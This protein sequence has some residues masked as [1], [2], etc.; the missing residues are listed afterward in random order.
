M[1]I[2]DRFFA[3]LQPEPED[4]ESAPQPL[5]H[6]YSH[7]AIVVL[8]DPGSGKSASFEQGAA[9][10][11]NAVFILYPVARVNSNAMTIWIFY[12]EE[13]VPIKFVVRNFSGSNSSINQSLS[14]CLQF[15]STFSWNHKIELF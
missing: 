2:V 5:S 4:P 15:F 1:P 14:I 6:Y 10:E 8:G 3:Q 9:T 12:A 11:P 13:M 7:P